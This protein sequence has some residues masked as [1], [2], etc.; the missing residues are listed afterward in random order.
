M[1]PLHGWRSMGRR[2]TDPVEQLAEKTAGRVIDL[3]VRNL[4]VS[5]LVRRDARAA[6]SGSW[7]RMPRKIPG[8][9]G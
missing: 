8:D 7:T 6:R 4:D 3:V 9:R 1:D 2:S 5:A